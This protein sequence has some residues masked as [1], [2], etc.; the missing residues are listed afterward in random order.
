MVQSSLELTSFSTSMHILKSRE[1]HL[2]DDHSKEAPLRMINYDRNHQIK[3]Q[4]NGLFISTILFSK[5]VNIKLTPKNNSI[6]K[7]EKDK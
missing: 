1:E 6:D 5:N 4:M 2:A 3:N 7:A